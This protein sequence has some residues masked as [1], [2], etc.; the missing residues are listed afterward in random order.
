MIELTAPCV[1]KTFTMDD[2][3]ERYRHVC[4]VYAIL[5]EKAVPYVDSLMY[6][7]DTTLILSPRGT[8]ELPNT[9]EELL[10]AIICVLKALQVRVL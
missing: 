10:C 9:E 2:K 8:A 4:S 7:F 5:K 6:H 1:I 3:L